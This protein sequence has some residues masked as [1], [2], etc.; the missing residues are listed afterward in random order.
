MAI[1]RINDGEDGG[2]E[3]RGKMLVS[4]IGVYAVRLHNLDT[5]KDVVIIGPPNIEYNPKGGEF[6]A[7]LDCEETIGSSNKTIELYVKSKPESIEYG[8]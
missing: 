4:D 7:V 3:V 1:T 2:I 5:R 6:T 8:Y